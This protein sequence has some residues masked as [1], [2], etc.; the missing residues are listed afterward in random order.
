MC[1][2]F[3]LNRDVLKLTAAKWRTYIVV[4]FSVRTIGKIFRTK[5]PP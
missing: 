5:V 3:L 1:W 4:E 2:K